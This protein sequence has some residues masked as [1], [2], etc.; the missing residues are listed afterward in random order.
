MEGIVNGKMQRYTF[1]EWRFGIDGGKETVA[2]LWAT[3]KLG[4]LLTEIRLPG[5]READV[6]AESRAGQVRPRLVLSGHYHRG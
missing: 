6:A 4:S 1:G 5:E 2:R 3:R